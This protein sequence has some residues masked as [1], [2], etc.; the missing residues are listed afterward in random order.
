MGRELRRVPQGWKH[1][2]DDRGRYQPMYDCTYED[3]CIEHSEMDRYGPSPAY[4]HPK[5]IEPTHYQIYETVSEGT[6]ISPVF[7]TENETR[8]WL[9][10]S[11]VSEAAATRFIAEKW[12]SMPFA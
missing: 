1:P 5:W 12:I 10:E 2:K 4:Y 6:P 11:G 3:A 8:Q 7:E 9:I